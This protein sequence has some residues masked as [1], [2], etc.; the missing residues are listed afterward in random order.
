MS[1]YFIT[2]Q[3]VGYLRT[4][5]GGDKEI[6]LAEQDDLPSKEDARVWSRQMMAKDHSVIFTRLLEFGV[7][8]ETV[9]RIE[10]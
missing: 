3:L 10:E 8:T 7:N 4:V 2:V 1:E 6:I 9:E 5:T